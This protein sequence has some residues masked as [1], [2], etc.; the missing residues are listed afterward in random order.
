MSEY[1]VRIAE[2]NDYPSWAWKLSEAFNKTS[3][4][5]YSVGF[6]E[7][8]RFINDRCCAAGDDGVI[9]FEVFVEGISVEEW[10]FPSEEAFTMFLLRWS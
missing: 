1:R 5:E 6:E 2:G 9:V 7:F 4:D 10:C 8:M 3:D